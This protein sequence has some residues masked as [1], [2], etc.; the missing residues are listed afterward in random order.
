MK[1]IKMLALLALAIAVLYGFVLLSER[2]NA[3]KD[4]EKIAELL[5]SAKGEGL[6]K[7][8][9]EHSEGEVCEHLGS[10]AD[11]SH[12]CGSGSEIGLSQGA[13]R[14]VLGPPDA[15]VKVIAVVP[16]GIDCHL[17]TIRILRE[18]AKVEPKRV[19]VEIYDM[20]SP[21]GQRTL[22]RY[23]QHCASVFVNGKID[24][25]I[26]VNGK[27]RNIYC[28]RQPNTPMSTYNS[29]DLIEVVHLELERAYKKGFDAKALQ[30]LRARGKQIMMGISGI[31]F[32]QLDVP[33]GK[34]A[35]VV[36]EVLMPSEQAPFYRMFAETVKALKAVKDRYPDALAV[37]IF[38]LMTKEGQ[39]R[40][41]QLQLFAPAIVIN[42]KTLHEIPVPKKG[43]QI[44]STAFGQGSRLFT[45]SDVE[46][47]VL[48]YLQKDEPKK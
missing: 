42:G 17:Q 4:D 35:K 45:P 44:I 31:D 16:L 30:Q 39:E 46:K 29:T 19:R 43:K 5:A 40:L 25:T 13:D 15:K 37:R 3:P 8:M 34:K 10:E 47:V 26:K 7:E 36:A 22:S 33:P 14:N 23:G 48:Y 6:P 28:Q 20:S 1:Q 18:I 38:S 9:H 32:P 2:I 24:F 41:R 11:G 12:S 21:Q 27:E